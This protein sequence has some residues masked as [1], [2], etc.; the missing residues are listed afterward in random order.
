MGK[1]NFKRLKMLIKM[2]GGLTFVKKNLYRTK[3]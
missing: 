1:I 3:N 2:N